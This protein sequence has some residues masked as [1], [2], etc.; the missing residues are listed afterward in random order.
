MQER[1]TCSSLSHPHD[2]RSHPRLRVSGR[3]TFV[4]TFDASGVSYRTKRD[5]LQSEFRGRV[6][7][8]LTPLLLTP[9]GL[10][11]S[12]VALTGNRS[13]AMSYSESNRYLSVVIDGL[14]CKFND[15]SP[16]EMRF[17]FMNPSDVKGGVPW[18]TGVPRIVKVT[19]EDREQ[20]AH[21]PLS[22]L[23]I[24]SLP[25]CDRSQSPNKHK[26]VVVPLVFQP[27]DFHKLSRPTAAKPENRK[28]SCPDCLQVGKGPRE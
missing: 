12:G 20:A 2:A 19:D 4:L 27:V 11:V 28:F 7:W 14:G 16:R 26:W 6:N 18:K 23:P 25:A 17:P 8:S 10:R 3:T 5:R 1:A 22:L 24:P 9:T 21:D 13:A 15:R